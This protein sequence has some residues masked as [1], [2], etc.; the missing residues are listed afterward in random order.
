MTFMT[1]VV[2]VVEQKYEVGW[3]KRGRRDEQFFQQ[4]PLPDGGTTQ[5][6]NQL[7]LD[8]KIQAIQIRPR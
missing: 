7:L 2:K 3:G 5:P 1:E 4:M 6:R 8:M